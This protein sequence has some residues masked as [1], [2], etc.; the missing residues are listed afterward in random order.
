MNSYIIG[1]TLGIT[2]LVSAVG[3]FFYKKNERLKAELTTINLQVESYENRLVQLTE[4]VDDAQKTMD[5][6]HER[7]NAIEKAADDRKEELDKVLRTHDINKI[8]ERKASLLT[9]KVNRA[10]A[11]V[12]QTFELL[13]RPEYLYTEPIDFGTGAMER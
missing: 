3:Y 1:A 10:S 9:R 5:T 7:N 8:A 11:K 13:T 12:M 6:L 2:L 4:A